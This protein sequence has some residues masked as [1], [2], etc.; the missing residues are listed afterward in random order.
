[1][2]KYSHPYHLV[3]NSP[4]P[5][6]VSIVL[7]NIFASLMMTIYNKIGG[8][9]LLLWSLITLSIVVFSWIKEIIN[10]GTFIGYHTLIVKQ[11]LMFGFILFV[12]SEIC[13]FIGLFFGFFYN[14][15]VPSIDL[16]NEW[17]PIGIS[18]LNPYSI[19]LLNTALLYFSGITITISLN[20]LHTADN[21][22]SSI[23]YMIYTILLGSIFTYFQY[24]EYCTSSFTLIDSFYGSNF[25]ILT[26]FHGIH[27]II[28]TILLIISFIR[29]LSNHFLTNHHVGF[30]TSSI[31]WHFVDY[32]WLI[33]YT[34]LY[35][36]AS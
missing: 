16:G 35:C 3:G 9:N 36:W 7:L 11:N 8:S 13:I 32:V 12:I 20:Y 27:V 29:I 2:K 34:F 22:K 10:E 1:M 18:I 30:S 5:F 31:Y 24:V 17:P 14:S 19:P 21:K 6:I 23:I 25:Y 26:G 28:G 33:L 15:F 4:W